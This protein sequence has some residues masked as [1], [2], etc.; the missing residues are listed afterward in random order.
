MVSNAVKGRLGAATVCVTGDRT[1]AQAE[2]DGWTEE[3]VGHAGGATARFAS[4]PYR[5]K[6]GRRRFATG[7][8]GAD[9]IDALYR[10]LPPEPKRFL[11][12]RAKCQRCGVALE[13]PTVTH[14]FA[15]RLKLPDLDEF[16]LTLE[17]PAV[18]C[19]A[20][21]FVH[22]TGDRNVESDVSDAMIAAFGSGG[23]SY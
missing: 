18:A 9:L 21:G 7:D 8:F 11:F 1:M 19:R 20:C 5:M 4:L 15:L 14:S 23:L 3:L 13:S 10:A 2:V 12:G 22:R 17:M 6:D 16:G